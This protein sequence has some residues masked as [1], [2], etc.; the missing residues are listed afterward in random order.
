MATEQEL[1]YRMVTERKGYAIGER[2]VVDFVWRNLSNRPLTVEIVDSGVQI[3]GPDGKSLP[4][5]GLTACF[6]KRQ[7]QELLP[8][9][10]RKSSMNIAG[11][12]AGPY[13]L[14]R[15]GKYIL[16]S[17]FSSYKYK[18]AKV[19][20]PSDSPSEHWVGKLVAP[21]LELEILSPSEEKFKH[22]RE[23]ARIGDLEA[24]QFAGLNRDKAAIPMLEDAYPGGDWNRRYLVAKAL[25]R[26]STDEAVLALERLAK[27]VTK[28]DRTVLIA[29][30][31]E[32]KNPI[33][34]P[35]L[36]SYLTIEDDYGGGMERGGEK[37]RTLVTRKVAA[38]AL[39]GFSISIPESVYQIPLGKK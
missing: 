26:I 10:I 25:A 28:Q 36:K 38:D 13:E 17:Q 2:I 23:L 27:G 16:K 8:G 11:M 29:S 21:D 37:F 4:Y 18:D 31:G 7:F 33:A 5:Q 24:I 6:A 19:G 3:L 15:P 34:I 22:F 1:E 14:L 30:M 20:S 35:I 32:S 9:A 39:H 12:G